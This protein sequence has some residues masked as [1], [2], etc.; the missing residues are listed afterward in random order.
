MNRQLGLFIVADGMGGHICGEIASDTAVT[1]INRHIFSVHNMDHIERPDSGY[2]YGILQGAFNHA[3]EAIR[4]YARVHIQPDEVMGTTVSL[5]W[6]DNDSAWIGHIGDSCILRLRMDNLEKLTKDHTML[7]ERLDASP[8]GVIPCLSPSLGHVLTRAI[9]A[10]PCIIPDIFPVDIQNGDV[11]MICSDGLL[12]VLSF[13]NILHV[14]QSDGTLEG[15]C[16]ILIQMTLD[17]GAPDNVSI[18]I[19]ERLF[20]VA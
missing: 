13:D 1:E 10:C 2:Y 12:Q 17:G 8:N 16:K 4:E 7:Q 15:K 6:L 14:L 5:L 19:I 20:G 9:G 18:I 11:F 3:N